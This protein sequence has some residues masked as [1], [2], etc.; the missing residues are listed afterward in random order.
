MKIECRELTKEER[1]S[2]FY[3]IFYTLDYYKVTKLLF[4][5]LDKDFMDDIENRLNKLGDKF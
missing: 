3:G 4:D 1:K 5:S 2:I